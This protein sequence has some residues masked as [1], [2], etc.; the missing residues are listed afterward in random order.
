M[1]RFFAPSTLIAVAALGVVAYPSHADDESGVPILRPSMADKYRPAQPV[2]NPHFSTA[3]ISIF[4]SSRVYPDGRV[5]SQSRVTGSARG[6]ASV[7]GRA[8]SN[9]SA[10]S[11][12]YG[13]NEKSNAMSSAQLRINGDSGNYRRPTNEAASTVSVTKNGVQISQSVDAEE[14]GAV[15]KL[16]VITRSETIA[17]RQRSD[18]PIEVRI[19]SRKRNAAEKVYSA[20]DRDELKKTNP[21]LVRRI[22]AFE[23]IVGTAR[24]TVDQKG[25]GAEGKTKD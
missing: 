4:S 5:A 12:R 9:A 2:E 18:G 6:N 14:H 16:N 25:G 11:H 7:F 3:T 15:T 22:E 8:F 19:Q 21:R 20:L 24:A 10:M 13:R 1:K 17:V 23:K